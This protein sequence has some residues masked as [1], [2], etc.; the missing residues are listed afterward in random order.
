MKDIDIINVTVRNVET[1]IETF[2]VSNYKKC[3]KYG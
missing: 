1:V 3:F 2:L